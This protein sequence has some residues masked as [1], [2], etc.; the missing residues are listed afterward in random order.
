MRA[1]PLIAGAVVL[2]FGLLSET[3]ALGAGAGPTDGIRGRSLPS[4]VPNG[5]AAGCLTFDELSAYQKVTRYR[6]FR[7]TNTGGPLTVRP[8]YPGPTFTP[9]NTVLPDNYGSFGNRTR[10]TPPV[11]VAS[12]SVTMGDFDADDDTIHLEAFDANGTLLASDTDVVPASLSGGIDLTVTTD[13]DVIAYAEFWAD[14][15]N[16][17]YFD[18][19]CAEK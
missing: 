15:G 17:V 18:N 3:V 8:D 13:A 12:V 14:F 7:F 16:S 4:L 19:I 5:M 10:V 1:R 9:P 2:A 11:A 6:G